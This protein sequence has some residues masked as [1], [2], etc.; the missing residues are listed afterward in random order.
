MTD[1]GVG[2]SGAEGAAAAGSASVAASRPWRVGLSRFFF[3]LSGR[4]GGSRRG[5]G[6]EEREPIPEMA[7]SAVSD[8]SHRATAFSP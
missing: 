1:S 4:G 5:G 6:D 3:G 7:G 8:R 2:G